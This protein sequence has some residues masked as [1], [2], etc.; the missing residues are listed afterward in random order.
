[1]PL[2]LQTGVRVYQFVA[3]RLDDRRRD[4]YPDGREEYETDWAAAHDL[5]K[6]FSEAVHADDSGT[7]EHLLQQLRDMA[8]PWQDHPHHPDNHTDDGRLPD[9]TAPG[10]QP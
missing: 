1:M 8:A 4:Q 3:D 9:D 2:D 10:S 7:A 5:E 6:A